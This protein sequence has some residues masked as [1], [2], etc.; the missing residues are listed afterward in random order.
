MPFLHIPSSS[1][2]VNL[3]ITP[4]S[5]KHLEPSLQPS[6]VPS[7][8]PSLES[9][10][11]PNTLPSL[12]PNTAHLA[13]FQILIQVVHKVQSIV[14]FFVCSNLKLVTLVHLLPSIN[15]ILVTT[16]FLVAVIDQNKEVL[17]GLGYQNLFSYVIWI[18]LIQ[19]SRRIPF[20][21]VVSM[22]AIM[23]SLLV[24]ANITLLWCILFPIQLQK[25]S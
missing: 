7:S 18:V 8:I 17:S 25:A 19:P 10:I 2:G 4:S 22:R 6:D 21:V 12:D 24:S 11:S 13:L 9:S 23:V 16:V 1:S 20:A 15:A 3:S 14:L 5:F